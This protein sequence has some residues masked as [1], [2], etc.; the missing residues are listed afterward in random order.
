MTQDTIDEA[1]VKYIIGEDG[2]HFELALCVE[3]AMPMV[4][5]RLVRMVLKGVRE[6]FSASKWKIFPDYD[7]TYSHRPL[8]VLRKRNWYESPSGD[9]KTGIVLAKAKEDFTDL[10]ICLN[11]HRDIYSDSKRNKQFF[12]EFEKCNYDRAPNIDKMN[13]GIIWEY[14]NSLS[15]NRWGENF[16]KRAVDSKKR[17]KIVELLAERI[18]KMAELID[19]TTVNR[20]TSRRPR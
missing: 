1:T 5:M 7:N 16:F 2:K 17:E 8:I 10:Y 14:M 11:F 12:S 3:K 6:K 15:D 13:E 20:E 18:N 4:R 9:Q 19:S